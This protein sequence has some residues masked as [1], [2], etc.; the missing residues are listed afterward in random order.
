MKVKYKDF[1]IMK[2]IFTT[3]EKMS[4][5]DISTEIT[6]TKTRIEVFEASHSAMI[7][8]EVKSKSGG[9]YKF[10]FLDE[11]IKK[12]LPFLDDGTYIEIKD[13][14][15]QF[16]GK[17]S[18]VMG[19]G[20]YKS[21]ENSEHFGEFVKK[22]G[23]EYTFI[24]ISS[25]EFKESYNALRKLGARVHFNLVGKSGKGKLNLSNGGES[26]EVGGHNTIDI[27]TIVE[28]IDITASYHPDL[29]DSVLPLLGLCD[30]LKLG[31]GN[32]SPI[33]FNPII[34]G[35]TINIL[36]APNV[37]TEEE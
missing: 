15:V 6:K 12:V 1:K 25:K 13:T 11:Y 23:E 32:D 14:D 9:K 27:T 5:A 21:D 22:V 3:L 19:I 10:A 37:Q 34:D 8:A 7:S 20:D 2:A 17:N 30:N 31:F 28:D 16:K 33:V 26:G 29:L 36:V 35:A 24:T 4:V 18:Y